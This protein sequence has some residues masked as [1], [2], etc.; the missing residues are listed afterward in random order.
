MPTQQEALVVRID[1]EAL[2]NALGRYHLAVGASLVEGDAYI[3]AEVPLTID[4]G[5]GPE[6]VTARVCGTSGVPSSY[7]TV[8][9][10]VI[11]DDNEVHHFYVIEEGLKD[12]WVPRPVRYILTAGEAQ[13][14]VV[15]FLPVFDFGNAA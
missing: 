1:A 10:E 7:Q 4:N 8:I 6:T 15:M 13:R 11:D 14:L 12:K 2:D 9:L 3:E 5:D